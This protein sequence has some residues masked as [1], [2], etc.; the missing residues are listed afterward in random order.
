MVKVEDDGRHKPNL[1]KSS[2]IRHKLWKLHKNSM[3][4]RRMPQLNKVIRPFS[5]YV[6]W[7]PQPY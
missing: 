2:D 4:F 5:T 7:G 3:E 6:D 1:D